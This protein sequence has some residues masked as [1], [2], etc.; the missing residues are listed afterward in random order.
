MNNL[1]KTVGAFGALFLV[2]PFAEFSQN[3]PTQDAAG[4]ATGTAT[5]ASGESRGEASLENTNWNLT[6][7]GDKDV[8]ASD[9]QH[10]PYIFLDSSGNR[11]SGS[12]GCNRISGTY[13]VDKQKIR[14]GPTGLTM[15]ACP[16][17]MDREKD[18]MEALGET[19]RW[20]IRGNELE[21][22]DE[23]G[24]LLVQFEGGEAK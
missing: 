1:I 23:D 11:V 14:F 17:G 21:F 12:G 3:G 5:V 16:T 2:L 4:V 22:Y 10:A 13:R 18:F 24:K 7:M 20:K 8:A 19:R 15:M 6:R 9:I